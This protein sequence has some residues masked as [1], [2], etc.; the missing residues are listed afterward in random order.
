MEQFDILSK[1]DLNKF[2]EGINESLNDYDYNNL[3]VN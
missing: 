2:D 3:Y 1:M